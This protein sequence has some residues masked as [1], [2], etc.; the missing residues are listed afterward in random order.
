MTATTPLPDGVLVQFCEGPQAACMAPQIWTALEPRHRDVLFWDVRPGYRAAVLP[1][2]LSLAGLCAVGWQ[3][4][5]FLGMGWTVPV[6]RGARAAFL[7]MCF[8]GDAK[9]AEA[10][11]RHF[12]EHVR[13]EGKLDSLVGVVPH[14]FRHMRDF[15]LRMGFRLL[16]RIPGACVL[17]GHAGRIVDADFMTWEA[18]RG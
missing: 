13:Q 2:I 4:G 8:R 10:C 11:G 1:R 12:L 7:H 16:G 14:P 3:D 6:L 15:A 17:A 9:T 18:R 5:R